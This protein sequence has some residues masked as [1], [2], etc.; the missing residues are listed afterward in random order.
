MR[1][2]HIAAA[3]ALLL[4][5]AGSALAQHED[6]VLAD[7]FP[8]DEIHIRLERT[9]CAGR[10]PSYTVDI[11]D[12]GHVTYEGRERV[13]TLGRRTWHVP[14]EDVGELAQAFIEAG[15]LEA[16]PEYLG[17]GE[18]A[19]APADTPLPGAR[20]TLDLGS[21]SHTVFLYRDFPE[22][23][24]LLPMRVDDTAQVAARGRAP[25]ARA[26]APGPVS[27]E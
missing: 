2:R 9:S 10:C 4:L 20:L 12:D 21:H 8:G 11:D 24:A 22:A 26:A 6:I 5:S 27:T 19:A 17:D 14:A 1:V 15:F 25:A 3:V 18:A 23:L 16:A 13:A 7:D